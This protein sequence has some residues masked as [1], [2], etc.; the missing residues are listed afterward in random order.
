MRIKYSYYWIN[1]SNKEVES[2]M[3]V[4]IESLSIAFDGQTIYDDLNIK[5][6]KGEFVAILGKSGCG[7][8]VLLNSI[9]GAIK[10]QSGKIYIGGKQILSPSKL[11]SVCYQD[12]AI[13]PWLTLYENLKLSGASDEIIFENAK[14]LQIFEHLDKLP[15]QVSIGM[16]QRTSI[17]RSISIQSEVYLMDEPLCSVDAI[18]ADMIRE[19]IK[20][21]LLNKTV[22]LVTHNIDEALYLA[23]RIICLRNGKVS[24]DASAGELSKQQILKKL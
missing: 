20:R 7:K 12:F 9:L 19:D 2:K 14:K 23:D 3:G 22:I 5:I 11:V 16:K 13:L 6:N 1:R 8:T 24:L 4:S 17:A 15:K 18:T 21:V 10:P